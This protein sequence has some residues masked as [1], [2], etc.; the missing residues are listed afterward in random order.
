[1]QYGHGVLPQLLQLVKLSF[2][3]GEDVDYDGAKVGKKPTRAGGSFLVERADAVFLER[4]QDGFPDSFQLPFALA[5]ADNKV[6]G[7]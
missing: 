3:R 5:G 4:L 2:G 1:M 6:V 7:E